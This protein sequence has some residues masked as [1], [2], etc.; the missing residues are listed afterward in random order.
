MPRSTVVPLGLL[1]GLMCFLSDAWSKP[2]EEQAQ[3]LRAIRQTLAHRQLGEIDAVVAKAKSLKGDLDYDNEVARLELAAKYIQAFWQGVDNGA[4][5]A[6]TA[7]ELDVDGTLCSVVDYDRRLFVIRAAGEN[8]RYSLETIPP[9]L[10]LVLAQLHLPK[11][12]A[13]NQAAFG[14][15]L[16][17]DSKGDRAKARPYLESAIQGGADVKI[18]LAELE[19]APVPPPIRLPDLTPAA[20][21]ALNP[22]Q[23]QLRSKSGTVYKREPLGKQ[24]AQNDAGQLTVSTTESDVQL[25]NKAR[26]SGDFT[27]T[28]YLKDVGREQRFG[29]YPAAS[30]DNA[31]TLALPEGT[32]K[33]EL[34]RRKGVFY[35]KLNDVETEMPA[36]ATAAAKMAGFIGVELMPDKPLVVAGL[37]LQTR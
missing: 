17:I 13:G 28:L 8:K 7:G 35:L 4:Q 37:E 18:L 27:C 29:L 15:F 12:N 19:V 36:E 31:L 30:S 24:G 1:I 16:A 5:K 22:N 6:L 2:T 32:V 23:W 26:L 34:F 9:K 33:V 20:R 21:L 25:L 10:A 3:A 11:T 14:A